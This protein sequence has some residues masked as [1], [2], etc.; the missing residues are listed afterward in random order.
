V[1]K[2]FS[3][4]GDY[5]HSHD[6]AS[7]ALGKALASMNSRA[8]L[9]DIGADRLPAALEENPALVIL[10]KIN[11]LN[12][13][14]ANAK[15]WMTPEL[16][17]RI[18]DYVGSGGSFIAWHAG[19]AGYP[20]DG[21]FIRMLGGSFITHP[22]E[23]RI[24]RYASAEPLL[25]TDKP[26]AFEVPDEHYFV[27][28]DTARTN[29]FLVSESADGRC[30]AGWAHEYGRGRVLCITPTHRLEGFSNP[31]MLRLLSDSIK[32]CLKL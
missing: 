5:Y 27:E 14:G 28:C 6:M 21:P 1:K 3:V 8:V 10:D 20:K 16:E 12:P 7:E 13:D 32:W 9:E 24:T 15:D 17:K 2:I 22:Q 29:V 4:L 23:N 19:L 11:R 30:E 18:V 26:Y 25:I 31:E